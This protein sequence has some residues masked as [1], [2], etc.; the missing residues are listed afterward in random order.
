MV[1]R[2]ALSFILCIN[3]LFSCGKEEKKIEDVVVRVG[4]ELLTLDMIKNVFPDNSTN[5]T[6]EQIQN[7]IQLWVDQE[8]MYQEALRIGLDKDARLE[9]AMKKARKDFL[10]TI[11]LDSLMSETIDIPDQE[12]INYYELNKENF[13]RQNT[14]IRAL[15][16]LV[17]TE[18]AANNVRERIL[19]G[20]D[21]EKIASE[22]SIDYSKNKRVDLGYFSEEDVVPEIALNVFR[23]RAG[24]ISRPIK[25]EFGY[26]VFKIIDKKEPNSIR[27]Y[28]EVKDQI[29]QRLLAK[30]K[31]DAYKDYMTRLKGKLEVHTNFDLLNKLRK[32]SVNMNHH[33]IK[34]SM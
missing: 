22:M 15:Q 21:F 9:E 32:E 17:S 31:E 11:L 1:N 2:I 14:E 16:I 30:K 27:D 33:V 18:D 34:D 26:H 5:A 8:L 24:T 23:M 7:Y 25:S 28:E 12:L 13:I 20:E 10:V 4:N 6:G 29:V 3:I 19:R